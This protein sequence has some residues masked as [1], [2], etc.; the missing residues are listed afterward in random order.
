MTTTNTVPRW[1]GTQLVDS[2]VTVDSNGSVV[3]T[4]TYNIIA[5]IGSL[6]A[7]TRMAW[8]PEKAAF[9]AGKVAGTQWDNSN[10]GTRSTAMGYNTTASGIYSTAMGSDSTA[11]GGFSTALGYSTTAS[12]DHSTAMGRNT[13]ASG[14]WSTAMGYSTTASGDGSTAMGR[15]IKVDTTG[16]YS[17]GIGLDDVSNI[18]TITQAN[19]MA[20]MSG[21][22]GIGTVSPSEALDVSGTVK[23]TAFVGDGSGLTGLTISTANTAIVSASGGDYTTLQAAVS[24]V[25]D[26]CTGATATNRCLLRLMPG[27]YTVTSK[28]QIPSN[29]DIVGQGVDNTVINGAIGDVSSWN[30]SCVLEMKTATSLRDLTVK[31]T[32]NLTKYST[33]IGLAFGATVTFDR[34]AVDVTGASTNENS[35]SPGNTGIRTYGTSNV[36]ITDSSIKVHNG[37][38]SATYYNALYNSAYSGSELTVKRSTIIAQGNNA[39]NV[40]AVYTTKRAT[41]TDVT[42]EAK[43]SGSLVRALLVSGTVNQEVIVDRS[44]ITSDGY[45]IYS[46]GGT[47]RVF[48]SRI[49][50]ALGNKSGTMSCYDTRD[51]ATYAALSASCN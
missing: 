2:N 16:L 29:M 32:G 34:I 25:G 50:G 14:Y 13:T 22:V 49:S 24:K 36:T 33:G 18:P 26:W 11:S 40:R 19:T 12:G 6:G 5:D 37:I 3:A 46:S 51:G 42:L 9:R 45:G 10:V 48:S 27:V 1:D 41:L 43:G 4:G 7:G 15:D 39:T 28:L 8:Y 35:T 23:A 47:T 20:I 21:K 31:N 38:G 17:L 30:K 44:R